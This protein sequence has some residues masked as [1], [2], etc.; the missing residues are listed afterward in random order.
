[1]SAVEQMNQAIAD[2]WEA[3]SAQERRFLS[4]GSLFVGAALVY[5]VLLAP[6]LKGRDQYE[7]SI[8]ELRQQV[9]AMQAMVKEAQGFLS[10]A[11]GNTSPLTKDTLEA[12]LNQRGLPPAS[13][14]VTSDFAKVQLTNVPFA[15][16]VNFLV[17]IQKIQ[18]VTVLDA[19]IMP[20]AVEGSVNAALTLK[21]LSQ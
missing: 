12:L 21:Q 4:L 7:K 20:Q 1:M 6:A 18:R 13:V 15:N 17:E 19:S 14:S 11:P 8:P 2:F 3:R 9:A 5:T 16:L 10:Q